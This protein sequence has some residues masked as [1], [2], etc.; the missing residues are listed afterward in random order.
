MKQRTC[1][2]HFVSTS[3]E[4]PKT[5]TKKNTYIYIYIYT[6][7][8]STFVLS[9]GDPRN[10]RKCAVELP[11]FVSHHFHNCRKRQHNHVATRVSSE[12]QTEATQ[13]SFRL[14]LSLESMGTKTRYK[15]QGPTVLANVRPTPLPPHIKLSHESMNCFFDVPTLERA[16]ATSLASS[17]R[18]RRSRIQL[19][20]ASSARRVL[21]A[22]QEA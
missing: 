14:E 18:W 2:E 21:R 20:S 3:Q 6:M 13:V 1:V 15:G 5:P 4:G 17:R 22:W 11:L 7:C 10:V 8:T 19:L 16:F 9:R 12:Q